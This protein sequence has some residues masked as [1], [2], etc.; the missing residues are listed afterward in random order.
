MSSINKTY[1]VDIKYH[2]GITPIE[3]TRRGDMIDL[4]C[5]EHDLVLK[6]GDYYE[7]SLGISIKLPIGCRMQLY[8][9][10][11][12]YKK[13][14]IIMVSSGVI[15][16]SYCGDDDIIKFG[17]LALRDTVIPFD[18]RICQCE[19]FEKMPRTKFKI[20]ERLNNANRGGF[21]S[22]GYK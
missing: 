10:S 7:I 5:A 14:G 6:K 20:V 8:P 2:E 13:Y 9:R 15:D 12:T 18:E 1:Y 19:I 11:S 22:T 16:E 21:G 3:Q 4:R 17:V